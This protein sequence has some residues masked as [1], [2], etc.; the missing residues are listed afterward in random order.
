MSV[1]IPIG[2][3]LAGG[4]SSRM[5]QNKAMLKY[6]GKPLVEHMM[7]ILKNVGIKE[8]HISGKVDGYAG[9]EDA[10]PLSGPAKA[11]LSSLSKI[12]T[13]GSF[14]VVPVDMPLLK[15]ETLGLL[16]EYPQGAYF[17]G[18]PLPAHLRLSHSI[19]NPVRS[20]RSLLQQTKA[21]EILLPEHLL[22]T[23]KNV[24]TPQDWEEVKT[25]EC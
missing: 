4:A 24:N 1:D 25:H 13:S 14:L 10:E 21:E 7:D 5:G 12:N 22:A 17:R 23:M 20:V 2:L 16:L 19:A 8:I 18:F 3:V 6:N 11:I 9:L 15:V